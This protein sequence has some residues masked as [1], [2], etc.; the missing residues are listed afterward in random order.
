MMESIAGMATAMS[1]SQIANQYAMSVTKKVMDTEELA[2]QELL[3]MLP[4]TPGQG[5]Y[6]DTYA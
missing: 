3:K 4:P 2:G 1:A 5:K 6:I